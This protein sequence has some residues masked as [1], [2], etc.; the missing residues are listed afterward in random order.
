MAPYS[1][2]ARVH[3]WPN[4]IGEPLFSLYIMHSARQMFGSVQD[5]LKKHKLLFI[6]I[7]YKL[8]VMKIG[9]VGGSRGMGRWMLEFFKKRGYYTCFTSA[10]GES[11]F[12]SNVEMVGAVDTVLLCVPISA[13]Q[14]VLEEIYPHLHGKMLVEVASVKKFVIEKFEAL[15]Q[16]HPSVNCDFSSVHPM[17][18]PTLVHLQGQVMLFTWQSGKGE[19]AAWL[20][21]EFTRGRARL[22]DLDYLAHDRIMG[23]VQGL[24]H[25]NVFVS[26]RTLERLSGH[27]GSIKDFASPSY[28]IFLIFY[29]RYVLQ[30][31]QLYAEIQMY[32]EFVPEVLEI[33]KQEVENLLS[34]IK[35]KDRQAFVDYVKSARPYFEENTEDLGISSHLIEQLGEYISKQ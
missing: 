12:D 13:M 4:C 7:L 5:L 30:D 3:I 25:F 8:I 10:D 26:G 31:P 28:R 16:Q 15:Q 11:M 34:I 35:N 1:V 6:N 14:P 18:A 19:T 21:Q 17:F 33:F 29:A 22:F 9:I 24:N 23:V 20:R 2:L 27:T 32:N